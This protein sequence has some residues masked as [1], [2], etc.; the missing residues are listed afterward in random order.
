MSHIPE[1]FYA[2][3]YAIV[4]QIPCGRVL[5]YKSVAILAGYPQ[6]ARQVGRA[7]RLAPNGLKL[8][9]HRVVNSCGRLAPHWN[10]QQE[11]LQQEGVWLT[12]RGLVDM[13][14]F[15]WRYDEAIE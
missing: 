4:G 11:L 14:R 13:K 9:C 1:T 7:L 3:V 12:P 8:L 15:A 6:Y 5:S 2:Q 10:E